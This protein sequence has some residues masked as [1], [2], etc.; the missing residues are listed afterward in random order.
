MKKDLLAAVHHEIQSACKQSG[1]KMDDV[2]LIAV[3]KNKPW[4]DVADFLH[5]GQLDFGENY[6]Q[7][8]IAK[9]EE[10]SAWSA[11]HGPEAKWHFIGS[12]QSNKAKFLPKRFDL[13]HAL[14]SLSLA[15][16]LNRAC[17]DRATVMNC[18]VEV[19]VDD[20]QSK[21]GVQ[22]AELNPLLEELANFSSLKVLGL[23]CIPA[24][25]KSR[26]PFA[27]LRELLEAANKSGAYSSPLKE[28]S[29]GMSADFQEAIL[30]G[31][32]FVRVGTRLFGERERK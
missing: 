21:G 8:A 18:L 26:A 31:A 14:D 32:T 3:S 13:F 27:R 4:Q 23:M 6:V 29:M 19:N 20:E 16:K 7:E 15:Q 2:T 25:S 30:E 1:R 11:K 9:V 10:V 22:P 28:L 12:L 17:A 5:L 24:V